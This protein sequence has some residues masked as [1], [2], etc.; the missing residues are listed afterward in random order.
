MMIFKK[1]VPRRAFLKGLGAT[2]A[3]PWLDSMVPAFAAANE[4]AAQ[5]AT[6]VSYFYI[7]NGI[8]REGWLP[9]TAGTN[10]ELTPVLQNYA[11]FRN[12]MVVLSGLDGGSEFVGGHV[13][14]SSMWLTGIDP[15]KSLNDVYCGTSVDQV[16]AKE[17]GK[18]TQLDSLQLCIEDAAEIAGQS[19]GGYN[20]AYTNTISWRSPVMPLPMEHRPRAVFER[21]FGDGD[22]TDANSRLAALRRNRSILDFVTQ[23][24][25]RVMKGL[26]PGDQTKL[27]EFL[28]S[29]RDV[30]TRI[31]KAELGATKE[32]PTVERPIG[33]PP[34]EDHV[35]LMFDLLALSFQTDL[36]RVSTMMLAREYSELVYTTLGI[37]EPHHPLTH[38]RGIPSRIADAR[39]IDVY[40]ASLFAKFLEKLHNTPEGDGTLLDHSMIIYGAGMGDGDVHN[41]WNL[42]VALI[43]SANGKIKKGNLHVNYPKGTPFCNLHVAMLNLAGIPTEK[44][45]NSKEA[46]DISAFA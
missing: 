12:Q 30:E 19:Q 29:I 22:S 15:K 11:P 26:G 25:S 5:S 1:A 44:F 23:D 10:F 20:A 6:R 9:T 40:H 2:V 18:T 31:Q 35:K 46:L 32:L 3:L 36:T 17:F 8:I 13:R 21:L 38:H 43:G 37:T 34:Y 27:T 41:Q 14:G 24:V 42:P 28:D 4:V 16:F 39:K 45:G 33:I 7:P